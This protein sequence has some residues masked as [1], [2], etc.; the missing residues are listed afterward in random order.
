MF[1]GITFTSLRWLHS[2]KD[3]LILS[4]FRSLVS[5]YQMYENLLF[6]SLVSEYQ[7]YENMHQQ[8]GMV[9]RW[10]VR[11][12][13]SFFQPQTTCMFI[14]SYTL[15]AYST[16][17]SWS[18]ISFWLLHHLVEDIFFRFSCRS[19]KERNMETNMIASLSVQI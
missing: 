4:I 3:S 13:P 15:H 7:M 16:A 19:K 14:R 1:D 6:R 17:Y 5:E 11:W 2:H 8:S 12:I 18:I 9:Q 10:W